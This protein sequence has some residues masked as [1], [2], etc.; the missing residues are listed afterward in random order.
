MGVAVPAWL[1][2]PEPKHMFYSPTWST[3]AKAKALPFANAS[4][5]DSDHE[6]TDTPEAS[7]RFQVTD[8][9][10]HSEPSQV[11]ARFK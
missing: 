7:T 4:M 10:A 3:V 9:T 2:E 11:T 6:V 5:Y 1:C 8:A